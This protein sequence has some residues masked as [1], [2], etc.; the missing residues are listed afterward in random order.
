M[1]NACSACGVLLM[2][3][4]MY[5]YTGRTRAV[6]EVI[7]SGVL[8]RVRFIGSTFRFLLSNPGSIKLRPELGGGSLYDVGCYPVNFLG[9]VIDE[10]VRLG[11]MRPEEALPDHLAVECGTSVGVDEIFSALLRYPSGLIA[12]LNCGFN[13]QK[14]VFS[15]IV[16]TA[17]A[18][19]VPETFFDNPGSLTLT[20][21]EETREIAVDQSDR[22]R[23][24]IED[25][26]EAILQG[27]STQLGPG[28]SLRN[29]E[30]MDRLRAAAPQA[31]LPTR[32]SP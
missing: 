19:L 9:M 25:F 8:G 27:R 15:E 10:L 18:L 14:R 3:A 22:Y 16:G 24:E 11:E 6:L 5:R 13:A 28:E 7:R 1:I 21:G 17:G 23:L 29:L 31:F 26:A 20:L 30:I 2:E 12:S 32:L 4:F